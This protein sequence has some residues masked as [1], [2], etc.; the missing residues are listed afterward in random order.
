MLGV[1]DAGSRF[2]TTWP[3]VRAGEGGWA[4]CVMTSS[5]LLWARGCEPGSGRGVLR[6]GML[7][8]WDFVRSWNNFALLAV[9]WKVMFRS[10]SVRLRQT[11]VHSAMFGAGDNRQDS[12]VRPGRGGFT[13]S[14]WRKE[15]RSDPRKRSFP[16]AV[17]GRRPD[18]AG[19]A[20][21]RRMGAPDSMDG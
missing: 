14:G 4:G 1:R 18:G 11:T 21:G 6:C 8:C 9:Q 7:L 15:C 13:R 10:V 12:G 20:T 16:G 17:G 5:A 2:R 3:S 19:A